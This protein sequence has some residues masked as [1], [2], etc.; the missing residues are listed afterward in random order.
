M[1]TA[2]PQCLTANTAPSTGVLQHHT[3]G[4][5]RDAVHLMCFAFLMTRTSIKK[6]VKTVTDNSSVTPVHFCYVFTSDC[7]YHNTKK[8]MYCP[9]LCIWH[10][11]LASTSADTNLNFLCLSLVLISPLLP[12]PTL[13]VPLYTTCSWGATTTSPTTLSPV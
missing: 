10:S 12:H 2:L 9:I 3:K 8:I 4:N 6:T 5:M 11:W 13:P 1:C 7:W